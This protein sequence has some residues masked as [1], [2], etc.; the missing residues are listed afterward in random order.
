MRLASAADAWVEDDSVGLQVELPQAVVETREP[1]V[2]DGPGDDVV[3]RGAFA[4]RKLGRLVGIRVE[5]QD[6][7]AQRLGR[8][9]LAVRCEHEMK[10]RA[11]EPLRAFDGARACRP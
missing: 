1:E 11:P 4:K 8:V 2:A 6:P 3:R 10:R 5:S 9:E 7:V